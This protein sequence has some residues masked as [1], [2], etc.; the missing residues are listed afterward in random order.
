MFLDYYFRLNE[1]SSIEFDKELD[2]NS[3]NVKEGDT[4]KVLITDSDQVILQKQRT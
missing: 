3:L 1:D 4:F 2:P